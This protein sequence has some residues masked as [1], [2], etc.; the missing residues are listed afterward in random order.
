MKKFIVALLC[1]ILLFA[2]NSAFIIDAEAAQIRDIQKSDSQYTAAVWAVDKG[3]LTLST[4]NKFNKNTVMTEASLLTAFAKLDKDYPYTYST[5]MIYNYYSELHIPLKGAYD[6]SKRNAA[7]TRG[8]FAII[9]AA[10]FGLDLSEVQAVRYLYLN[11]ITTGTSGNKTYDSYNANKK[12]TRGETAVFLY[13]MAKKKTLRVEGLTQAAK[14]ADNS[15]ITIPSGFLKNK[16]DD[17]TVDLGKPGTSVTPGNIESVMKEVQKIDLDKSSLIANGSD[18]A[19]V[20]IKLKNSFGEEIPYTESLQFK[21]TSKYNN[22]DVVANSADADSYVKITSNPG[23]AAAA[24]VYSDGGDVTFYVTAPKTTKSYQDTIYIELINNNAN[25]YATFKNKRIEVPIQYAPEAELR[26]TYDIYDAYTADYV[27]GG[28]EQQEKWAILP[29]SIP[30]GVVSI[31]DLDVDEKTFKVTTGTAATGGLVVGYEGAKLTLAGNEV[32]EYLFEKIVQQ[33]FREN[34]LNLPTLSLIM[35]SDINGNAAYDLSF[36]IVPNSFINEFSSGDPEEYAVIAYL[37]SLLPSSINEFS[38]AYYDSVKKIQTIF[39]SIPDSTVNNV[40]GLTKLKTPIS[41]LVQ[42]ADTEYKNQVDAQ[43]AKQTS[44]TKIKVSLVAPGGQVITNYKGPVIIEYNGVRQQVLFSTN[45]TNTLTGTGHAGTAV[46]IFDDLIYDESKVKVTLPYYAADTR[47]AKL[48]NNLYDTPQTT[49]IFATRPI[50]DRACLMFS[51]VAVV[52]DSSISMNKYD[53]NN[54]VGRVAKELIKKM[55]ADP[56]IA[57]RFD[58]AGTLEKKGKAE[59]VLS[60]DQGLFSQ[61]NRKGGTSIYQGVQ[62]AVNHFESIGDNSVKKAIIIISDGLTSNSEVSRMINLANANNI[63]LHTIT[64]GDQAEAGKQL[65]ERL[66]SETG[67]I[68]A[69]A[70][71]YKRL[72]TAVQIVYDKVICSFTSSNE[73]C[74]N[75]NVFEQAAMTIYPKVVGL[76]AEVNANCTK[77][78]SVQIHLYAGSADLVLDLQPMGHNYF[79]LYYNINSLS[80]FNLEN[81][82]DFIALDAEGNEMYR[83]A[84]KVQ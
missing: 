34:A 14:G 23:N 19:R 39:G 68:N 50:D 67:G 29:S 45:T 16:N 49:S 54:E 47:Y 31:Y 60:L 59:N 40:P 25:A 71:D 66:A 77:V 9:Y 55:E 69:H 5:D 15:R 20:S 4:G 52:V 21:V 37:V 65:M 13:R 24:T 28:N 53:P 8:D 62:T 26:V 44:H 74:S 78:A 76:T 1:T 41:G 27:G 30:P 81:E 35:G 56:T 51:E 80:S 48:F 32:S 36:S 11:E 7:V 73:V 79:E 42:L 72:S 70:T 12:L 38:M 43:K 63:E 18:Y 84:V 57:V 82:V 64:L 2:S 33:Y 17:I 22:S 46:A 83:H 10:M 3:V 6:K 58:K 75:I 61:Q